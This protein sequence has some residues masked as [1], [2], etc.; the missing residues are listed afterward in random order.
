MLS[1]RSMNLGDVLGI[2]IRDDGSGGSP[3]SLLELPVCVAAVSVGLDRSALHYLAFCPRLT[4]KPS[5]TL[6]QRPKTPLWPS[7][8]SPANIQ[9]EMG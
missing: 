2:N 6:M 8:S 7:R 3:A 4:M 5:C 1:V 9:K